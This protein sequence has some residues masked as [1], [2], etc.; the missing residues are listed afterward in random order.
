YKQLLMMAGMDRYFQIARCFRDE[1]LRA[2]RQPEFSQLD[3][4][5]SLV[6]QDDVLHFVEQALLAIWDEAG[7]KVSVP[8]RRMSWRDAMEKYGIDKPDLRYALEIQDLTPNV[9][10]DAAPFVREAIAAGG[11]LRGFLVPGPL[12]LSRKAIDEL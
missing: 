8:F 10:D 12:E 1:D 11:R 9:G 7:V 2:D 5:A 3:I 4:E 6:T